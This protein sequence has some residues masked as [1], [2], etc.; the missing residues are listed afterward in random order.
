M[1]KKIK[2]AGCEYATVDKVASEGNWMAYECSNSSSEYYKSLVNVGYNGEKNKVISWSGCEQ[3]SR[4]QKDEDKGF[5]KE[6]LQDRN[7]DSE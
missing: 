3:G 2:C 5:S 4:R 7:A 6:C 1:S